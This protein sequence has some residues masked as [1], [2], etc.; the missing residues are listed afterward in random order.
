VIKKLKTRKAPGADLV[1]TQMLKELPQEGLTHLRN[2]YNAIT[3]TGYWP[4]TFKHAQ[5]LMLP[6]PG[7]DLKDTASYRPISLLPTISL[8][9]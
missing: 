2:I 6:K 5:I 3:R 8:R 4:L 9:F 1:T 7:K